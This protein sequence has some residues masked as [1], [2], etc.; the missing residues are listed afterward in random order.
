MFKWTFLSIIL[1]PLWVYIFYTFVDN[2]AFHALPLFFAV[3]FISAGMI[4]S[5][6]INGYQPLKYT[7]VTIH[8]FGCLSLIAVM[9]MF[10]IFFLYPVFGNT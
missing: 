3:L 7:L 2:Q 6:Q 8:G 9:L 1:I 5:L 4:I 10:M